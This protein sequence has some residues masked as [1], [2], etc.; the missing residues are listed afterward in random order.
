MCTEIITC[1]TKVFNSSGYVKQSI[2]LI[3][4]DIQIVLIVL[5]VYGKQLATFLLD[6]IVNCLKLLQL[7]ISRLLNI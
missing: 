7:W 4:T 1:L 6:I 5:L 3:I 2:H